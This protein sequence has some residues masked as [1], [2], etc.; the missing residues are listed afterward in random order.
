MNQHTPTPKQCLE[1]Y[2]FFSVFKWLFPLLQH[3]TPVRPYAKWQ[4][5]NQNKHKNKTKRNIPLDSVWQRLQYH[6][7]SLISRHTFI[8]WALMLIWCTEN[9][10]VIISTYH[11]QSI[12]LCYKKPVLASSSLHSLKLTFSLGFQCLSTILLPI[13]RV[14]LTQEPTCEDRLASVDKIPYIQNTGPSVNSFSRML[15]IYLTI[16][17]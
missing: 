7:Y 3:T 9:R 10:V 12:K 14:S 17:D 1:I 16:A 4:T 13:M 15:L 5:G 2:F 8:H 6:Y 11:L